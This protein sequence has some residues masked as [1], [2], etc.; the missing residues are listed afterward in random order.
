M[1]NKD[2]TIL[3][4]FVELS[5]FPQ[6]RLAKSKVIIGRIKKTNEDIHRQP[7][8]IMR[9]LQNVDHYKSLYWGFTHFLKIVEYCYYCE[10]IVYLLSLHLVLVCCVHFERDSSPLDFVPQIFTLQNCTLQLCI[11]IT[12][13]PTGFY[14][15]G[16]KMLF[17]N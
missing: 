5:Y 12:V 9:N 4:D 11:S 13:P 16:N 8:F 7:Q 14:L 3:G 10:N 17:L 1:I 6:L 2:F 15:L